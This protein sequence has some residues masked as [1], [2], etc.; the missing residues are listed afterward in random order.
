[1]GYRLPFTQAEVQAIARHLRTYS[2]MECALFCLGIDTMLRVSDLRTLRVGD[3][4]VGGSVVEHFRLRQRKTHHAVTPTLTPY[5]R[6]VC[7]RWVEG[8]TDDAYLFTLQGTVSPVSSDWCRSAV[9]RW[10]KTIGLSPHRYSTHSLRRTKPTYLYFERDV[11]IVLI[12]SL[13]GHTNTTTTMRYL[14]IAEREA[15][16]VALVG[17]MFSPS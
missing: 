5:T 15:Q 17:D 12:A 8:K 14:H 4:A 1:M 6:A 9:K 10:A 2:L 13:L 16:R 11:D 7:G 3:V